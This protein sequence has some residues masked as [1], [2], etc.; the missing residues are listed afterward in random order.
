[1]G[2]WLIEQC[3]HLLGVGGWVN[4]ESQSRFYLSLS[5][6]SR[7]LSPAV[8]LSLMRRQWLCVQS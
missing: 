2:E 5:C 7:I 4:Y 8:K 6:G 1:M 3:D